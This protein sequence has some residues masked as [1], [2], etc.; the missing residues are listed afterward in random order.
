MTRAPLEDTLI[1]RLARCQD[2]ETRTAFLRRH[3]RLWD[4][5]FVE[6]LYARVVRLAHVDLQYATRLAHAARWLADELDDD[7]CRA[8]ILRAIGHIWYSRGRYRDALRNYKTALRLF[9]RLGRDVDVARTLNGALQSLISLGRYDEALAS[10]EQARAIFERNGNL[11]GLARL[12]SNV[13]NIMYRQ[14]RFDEALTHYRRAYEQLSR[15]GEPLDV[16]AALSNLAMTYASLDD[17]QTAQETYAQARGFCQRHDMS[18]LVVRADYNVAYLHYLRGEYTRALELFRGVQEHCDRID[19]TYHSALCDLDRSELYLELNL[20]DEAAELAERARARFADLAMPYEGAKAVTNL[21]IAT[22][23]RNDIHRALQL[24]DRARQ[25]FAREGNQVWLALVN[26]YQAFVLYRQGELD[27]AR[28]LCAAALELFA[29]AAVPG[30]AALCELLL[31]RVE[32]QAGNLD[33][34]QRA[35]DAALAKVAATEAPMLSYHAHLVHGLVREAQ[36]DRAAAYEAF[37]EAHD[38]LEHLRS[39][40]QA[41]GL[42]VAFLEDKT[43]VYESL[44]TTC[45]ALGSDRERHETAF[46][47]IENAKSRS[48]ADLIAFRAGMLPPRVGGA[49]AETV[50]RLRAQLTWQYHRIEHAEMAAKNHAPRRVERLRQRADA[51]ERQLIRSLEEV[52]RT[53]QEFSALQSGRASTLDEI[54]AAL[55]ADTMLLEYYQARGHYYVCILTRDTLEVVP[56]AAAASVQRVL[57]LLK[58]QLS[59]FRLGYE[60]VGTLAD[61]LRVAT[62]AHLAELYALLAAP[63][64]DRLRAPHLVVVPHD[65]LHGVPFH[66][67]HDGARYLIDD[68]T[69]SQA[70]SAS[71]YQLCRTKR[72]RPAGS[73]LIMGVPDALTPFI[74]DEIEAV[75]AVLPQAQVFVGSHATAERL[76][77]YSADSLLVHIATHAVF[78]R[79]NPMFSSIRLGDGP[80]GVYDLYQLRLSAELVTLSGCGTGL[81]TVVGGDE[82]LGLVRGLLYA[83]ARAVLVTLWDAH[84][85]SAADFMKSFYQQLQNGET[86]AAAA[87]HAMRELRDR[88]RHPFYWAPFTLVGDAF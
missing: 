57:R 64:R 18:L 28:A 63:I 2:A 52:R 86:K 35:C 24:F 84:D 75:A 5:G 80:I 21:A 82:L 59:K 61:Q 79:D 65:A 49:A 69:V 36:G 43:A 12:D 14:D 33:A 17:F 34:A 81:S 77:T 31:A 55:P 10:A 53:D 39:D 87:Q 72:E 25:L 56:L 41:E 30:K 44:V 50:R 32:L 22:S 1:E 37:R 70:P 51:L 23:R 45:L 54:R 29:H 60:Y 13:G 58:F 62:E 7:G 16:A 48:L 46:G 3:K 8:H 83:G 15:I 20:A 26:Y 67:L 78:R 85:R 11:L 76:R 66:A 73:A 74:R 71:V 6:R 4:P 9:R 38:D 40:L 88:F 68:F 27:R 47:Y 19:D 42:K